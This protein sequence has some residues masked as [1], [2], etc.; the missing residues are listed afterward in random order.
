MM[1]DTEVK[2]LDVADMMW[3]AAMK[4]DC[5]CPH[6]L[7]IGADTITRMQDIIDDMRVEH[8]RIKNTFANVEDMFDHMHKHY[9]RL[10]N[11][12]VKRYVELREDEDLF[13][14]QE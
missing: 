14:E 7:R 5:T 9:N 11:R 8:T 4:K 3:K 10:L 1:N 6:E 12:L 13:E 2:H